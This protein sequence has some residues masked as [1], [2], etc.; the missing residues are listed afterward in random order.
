MMK[1]IKNILIFVL[2]FAAAAVGYLFL[3]KPKVPTLETIPTALPA[4]ETPETAIGQEFLA[5]LLSLKDLRLD[6]S[7]FQN[8]QFRNL[9]DFSTPITRV[10]GSEGR[11]NPFAPFEEEVGTSRVET[12]EATLITP[13]AATLNGLVD[14]T[15]ASQSK[16]FAWGETLE[17]ANKTELITEETATGFYSQ[18]LTGLLPATTY[19]FRAEVVSGRETLRGEILSFTTLPE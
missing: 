14:L 10:P 4:G 6:E 2:V 18:T 1:R 11:P 12:G 5:M 8:N 3:K 17:V 13:A 9:R 19:F 7:L 15:L 16:F